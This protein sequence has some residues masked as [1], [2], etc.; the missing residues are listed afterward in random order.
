MRRRKSELLKRRCE[1]GLGE[2]G[3]RG[4]RGKRHRG[5]GHRGKGHRGKGLTPCNKL[6][7]ARHISKRPDSS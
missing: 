1:H 2:M 6:Y 3:R 5:K 7:K 4:H